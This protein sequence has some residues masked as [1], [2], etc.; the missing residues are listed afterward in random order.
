MRYELE[1]DTAM[2]LQVT[3][4]ELRARGS[5]LSRA[6]G[7]TA[8]GA[9]V[10]LF[11]LTFLPQSNPRLHY[12]AFALRFA[13]LV[14]EAAWTVSSEFRRELCRVKALPTSRSEKTP[15]ASGQS[16]TNSIFKC[17]AL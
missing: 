6:V 11:P 4:R 16:E 9:E 13:L 10:A 5:Q 1:A 17:P 3:F 7:P 8:A 15:V 14:G 2:N 12:S